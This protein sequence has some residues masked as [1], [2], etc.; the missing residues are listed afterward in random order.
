MGV[1]PMR[2]TG[3]TPVPLPELRRDQDAKMEGGE[4]LFMEPIYRVDGVP[5]TNNPGPLLALR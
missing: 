2:T 4:Y 3:G 1:P 5:E